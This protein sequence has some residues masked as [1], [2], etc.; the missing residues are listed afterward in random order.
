MF[1]PILVVVIVLLVVGL[2]LNSFVEKKA[3]SLLEEQLPELKFDQLEVQVFKNAAQ[4]S[5]IRLKLGEVE[6]N[7]EKLEVSGLNYWK[8][9][10]EKNIDLNTISISDPEIIYQTGA[11]KSSEKDSAV[12][13]KGN[14]KEKGLNKQ[15]LVEKLILN[16]GKFVLTD[17]VSENKIKVKNQGRLF[18]RNISM[19]F[20]P[21][22]EKNIGTY[23][24]TI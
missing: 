14:S 9:L 7:S 24:K 13:T 23:S 2:F 8:F 17:S 10:F 21:L 20:D 11:N 22:V 12:A 19:R 6:I 15:I 16:R 18:T 5:N 3:I 4:L 1:I